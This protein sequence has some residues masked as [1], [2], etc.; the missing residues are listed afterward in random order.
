MRC[1]CGA[2][3]PAGKAAFVAI[4]VE[5]QRWESGHVWKIGKWSILISHP[6]RRRLE[7]VHERLTQAKEAR[8]RIGE[9]EGFM[10]EIEPGMIEGAD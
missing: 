10:I 2:Y 5:G 4:L 9:D 8:I 1:I 6:D 7:A 3:M